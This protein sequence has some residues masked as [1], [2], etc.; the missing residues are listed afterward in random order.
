MRVVISSLALLGVALAPSAAAFAQTPQE[1]VAQ[2]QE[3]R[4]NCSDPNPDLRLAY[5]EAALAES[6]PTLSRICLELALLSDDPNIRDLGL[7]A[8]LARAERLIFDLE[9]PA[10]YQAA[11]ESAENERAREEV[12]EQWSQRAE[13]LSRMG[14]RLILVAEDVSASQP[15]TQWAALDENGGRR[16]EAGVTL[17]V[18]AGGV[19][20]TGQV[21]LLYAG[22][23]PHLGVQLDLDVTDDGALAG[24]LVW[25]SGEPYQARAE[26]F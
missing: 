26:L 3:W 24:D 10:A 13:F 25:A 19:D 2:I 6:D 5:I 7:R 1:R 23:R 9:M 11:I 16:G 18:R 15:I 17:T 22:Y 20:G 12:E 8:A 4:E 14:S 21:T